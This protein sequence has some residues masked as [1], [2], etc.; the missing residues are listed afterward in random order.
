MTVLDYLVLGCQITI[1]KGYN[2]PHVSCACAIRYSSLG[3]SICVP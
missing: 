1:Y 3:N 2:H